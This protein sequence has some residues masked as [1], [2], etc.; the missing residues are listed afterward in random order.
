MGEVTGHRPQISAAH[1]K[2]QK[3]RAPTREVDTWACC[4]LGPILE[5]TCFR[6]GPASVRSASCVS[7]D[8]HD[9]DGLIATVSAAIARPKWGG[10][11][12]S[13]LDGRG[14]TLSRT[15]LPRIGFA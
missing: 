4:V 12:V 5:A 2:I 1:E 11:A 7:C 9:T 8:S 14:I 6:P 10:L 13:R 15:L 3:A